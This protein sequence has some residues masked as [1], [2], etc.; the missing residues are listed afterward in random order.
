MLEVALNSR[1]KE[2]RQLSQEV[3]KVTLNGMQWLKVIDGVVL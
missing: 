2:M 1:G 3:D